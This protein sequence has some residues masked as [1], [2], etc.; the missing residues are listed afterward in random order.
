ME[1]S[2][3]PPISANLALM[4]TSYGYCEENPL[5]V[6]REGQLKLHRRSPF[7]Q[8]KTTLFPNPPGF[9]VDTEKKGCIL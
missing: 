4:D 8:A 5:F 2:P 7:S 1:Y 9:F 6:Q 3:L